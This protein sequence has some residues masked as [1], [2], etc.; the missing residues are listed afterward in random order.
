MEIK[1]KTN[2]INFI[3]NFFIKWIIFTQNLNKYQL[4]NI[5]ILIS[6]YSKTKQYEQLFE[7]ILLP[8]TEIDYPQ[9]LRI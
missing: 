7:C 3:L 4:I 1:M 8:N 9:Y 2:R 6:S 5:Y